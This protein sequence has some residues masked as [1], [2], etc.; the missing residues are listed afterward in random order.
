MTT[1]KRILS[2]IIASWSLSI[3]GLTCAYFVYL[4]TSLYLGGYQVGIPVGRSDAHLS[5]VTY[6]A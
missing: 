6:F 1:A 3:A 2:L 4:L 5:A